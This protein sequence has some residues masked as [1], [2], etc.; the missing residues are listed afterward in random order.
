M[1]CC[2][3]HI[4]RGL[5][6][7]GLDLTRMEQVNARCRGV[8]AVVSYC[9]LCCQCNREDRIRAGQGRADRIEFYRIVGT[10][11]HICYIAQ[12]LAPRGFRGEDT[13]PIIHHTW[14]VTSRH[15]VAAIYRMLCVCMCVYVCVGIVRI[16]HSTAMTSATLLLYCSVTVLHCFYLHFIAYHD[17]PY[18]TV[19]LLVL[20]LVLLPIRD[21]SNCSTTSNVESSWVESGCTGSQ[22]DRDR[23]ASTLH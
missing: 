6:Q 9:I 10:I 5:D 11:L 3:K 7:T 15:L 21:S 17:V 18:R 13:L 4:T 14:Y 2:P 1:L 8:S 22:A 12:L 19:P 23:H 16:P 20:V